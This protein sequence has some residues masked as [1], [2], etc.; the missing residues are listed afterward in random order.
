[1]RGRDPA[2]R[3]EPPVSFFPE[4]ADLASRL[5]FG[6]LGLGLL[7]YGAAGLWARW[8]A[9]DAHLLPLLFFGTAAA[10]GVWLM[11]SVF[12]DGDSSEEESGSE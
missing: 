10:A 11:R 12:Y 8:K 2:G 9:A 1:M 4:M 6:I 5:F 3:G 7:A